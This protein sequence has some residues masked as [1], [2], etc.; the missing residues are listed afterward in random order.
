MCGGLPVALCVVAIAKSDESRRSWSQIAEELRTAQSRLSQLTNLSERTGADMSL[1]AAFDLSYESL[2]PELARTYRRLAWHPGIEITPFIASCLTGGNLVE[3][4]DALRDLKHHHL[5]IEHSPERYRFT[6]LVHDHALEKATELEG[7]EARKEAVAKLVRAFADLSVAADMALR[8]YVTSRTAETEATFTG[9]EAAR[10]LDTEK[11]NLVDLIDLAAQQGLP[12]EILRLIEGLWPLFLDHGQARLWLRAGKLAIPAARGLKDERTLGRLLN[13][14]SLVRSRIGRIEGAMAD[15]DVAEEIWSRKKD[16][17]RV[18]QTRQRRGILAFEHGDF[19]EA[20]DFLYE[21]LAAD[22]HTGAE[23]HRGV[24]L[25]MLGRA[26]L[27]TDL[28]GKALECLEQALPLLGNSTR[29]QGLVR[30]A[31]GSALLALGRPDKARCEVGTALTEVRECG[32]GHAEGQAW[33]VLGEIHEHQGDMNEAMDAYEKAL[34]LFTETE[35]ERSRSS[36]Q[37][38]MARLKETR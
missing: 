38:R 31:L 24:T 21:A 1:R 28:P 35:D 32:A 23:H 8:P 2:P 7:P 14:R 30:I 36:V 17:K 27:A 15:L 34:E 4:K 18:A 16:W 33:A 5:M 19:Q 37:R 25:F 26:H 13:K 10:W 3:S 22:E 9:A 20:V 11:G 29:N 6:D 12:Q